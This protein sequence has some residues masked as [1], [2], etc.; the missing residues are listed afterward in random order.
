MGDIVK[1]SRDEKTPYLEVT[2]ELE[3]ERINPNTHFIY[4]HCIEDEI[5]LI[6]DSRIYK[7]ERLEFAENIAKCYLKLD[8]DRNKK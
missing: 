4:L 3:N 8:F 5:D 6:N 2:I 1:L 7:V